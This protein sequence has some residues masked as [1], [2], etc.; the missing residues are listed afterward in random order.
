[1]YKR[2]TEMSCLCGSDKAF[3][4][5]CQPYLSGAK[6]VPTAEALMRSRYTAYTLGDVQ[7]L[8]DSWY[9]LTRPETIELERDV[10]WLRLNI[11]ASSTD[12]VKFVATYRVNGK[13]NKL[14]ENSRFIREEGRY[15]Y[16]D[17]VV[18]Q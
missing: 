12:Q 17:G 5:C 2:K 7:Y 6:P 18:E 8:L 11:L 1:M 9:H 16:L 15:Y 3:S 13:A 10:Q 14:R 4:D